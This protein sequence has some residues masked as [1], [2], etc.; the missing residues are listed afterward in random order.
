MSLR[1]FRTLGK[2]DFDNGAVISEI[3][4]S[5]KQREDLM[6]ALSWALAKASMSPIVRMDQDGLDKAVAT[7]REARA[8]NQ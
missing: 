7:Y 4:T 1:K 3:D 8:A 6:E 2:R 5:L